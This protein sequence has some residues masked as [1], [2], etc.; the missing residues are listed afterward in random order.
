MCA[1]E[2][3]FMPNYELVVIC[4]VLYCILWYCDGDWGD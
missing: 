2:T 4:V 3:M 1:R